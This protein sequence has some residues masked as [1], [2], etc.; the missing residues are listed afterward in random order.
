MC[1]NAYHIYCLFL[2]SLRKHFVKS[3][4]GLYSD[5]TGLR[6]HVLACV[7]CQTSVECFDHNTFTVN[8]LY[9]LQN[10]WLCQVTW[11][12]QEIVISFT[13]ECSAQHGALFPFVYLAFHSLSHPVSITDL[14]FF[15][16]CRIES[17][18]SKPAANQ[19][20]PIMVMESPKG[21]ISA[22]SQ[23]GLKVSTTVCFYEN[24]TLNVEYVCL[25]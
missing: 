17:T 12:C 2:F 9:L 16:S 1:K 11:P 22:A 10:L 23:Q 8:T 6:M 13:C 15:S 18:M 19:R 3:C 25:N 20:S 4:L 21:I 14:H 24:L 7:S 5:I